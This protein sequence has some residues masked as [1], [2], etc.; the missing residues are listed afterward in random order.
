M[1]DYK[2]R[3]SEFSKPSFFSRIDTTHILD[4]HIGVDELGRMSIEFRSKFSARKVLGTKYIEVSQYKKTEYCTIRFSL[5]DKSLEDL[6]YKFCDDIVEKTRCVKDPSLGYNAIIDR[7]LLWKKLFVSAK[8]DILSEIEIMGLM[9]ELIFLKDY[10]FPLYGYRKAIEGW[11]GQD[12]T[13]KDFSYDAKWYEIKSVSYGK[14]SVLI[15]SLEQLDSGNFGELAVIFLER[16]SSLS[17][18]ETLNHLVI[19]MCDMI[20]PPEFKEKF[21]AKVES[22]GYTY[23]VAYED[24]VYALKGIKRYAV[25]SS[26]PRLTSQNVPLG[27][28][29]VKYE[30]SLFSIREKE[31]VS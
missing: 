23:N 29:A 12:H 16:M 30:I 18:G 10:L 15:S 27:I 14:D 22:S 4:W 7:F 5:C 24:Y 25:D 8:D 21:L 17:M 20:E 3:F 26:F 13:K 11:S 19:E 28:A 31:I 1:I 9:G 2:S 6:F